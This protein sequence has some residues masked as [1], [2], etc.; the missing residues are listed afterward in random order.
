MIIS[1]EDV[2]SSVLAAAHPR[3]RERCSESTIVSV[4]EDGCGAYDIDGLHSVLETGFDTVVAKLEQQGA[5]PL[6]FATMLK[7]RLVSGSP[8]AATGGVARSSSNSTGSRRPSIDEQYATAAAEQ[9]AALKVLTS[10]DLLQIVLSHLDLLDHRAKAVCKPWYQTWLTTNPQRRQLRAGALED[11]AA[12]LPSSDT[13]T[14]RLSR[15]PDGE[16]LCVS[17][18]HTVRFVDR[19]LR[20]VFVWELSEESHRVAGIAVGTESLY[21]VLEEDHFADVDG[22][23]SIRRYELLRGSGRAANWRIGNELL[24]SPLKVAVDEYYC[25]EIGTGSELFTVRIND[26]EELVLID[27]LTLKERLSF[28]KELDMDTLGLQVVP[29]TAELLVCDRRHACIQV[30]NMQGHHLRHIPC[31]WGEPQELVCLPDRLYLTERRCRC[32]DANQGAH[33]HLGHRVAGWQLY[34]LS[35]EGE[36]LQVYTHMDG[37]A[38]EFLQIAQLGDTL[39]VHE[40]QVARA[41]LDMRSRLAS[42][43]WR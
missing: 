10:P 26:G 6:A 31:P 16:H 35:L 1:V 41:P 37:P 42:L 25:L 12:W 4:L 40:N 5:A 30:F 2:V 39:I 15:F 29:A 27:P 34:V 22:A 14:L 13:N 19:E 11:S 33:G 23:Y 32:P 17:Y 36:V 21:M 28:G 43:Q 20:S 7:K 24:S 8:S 18:A 38:I 3:L 9:H